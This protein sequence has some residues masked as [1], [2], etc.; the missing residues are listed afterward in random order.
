MDRRLACKTS[1][2]PWLIQ[3]NNIGEPGWQ[4][5]RCSDASLQETAD[6][7]LVHSHSSH[8]QGIALAHKTLLN[9]LSTLVCFNK[10]HNARTYGNSVSHFTSSL[11]VMDET[12]S[13]NTKNLFTVTERIRRYTMVS[14]AR[15]GIPTGDSTS[16][17]CVAAHDR[18]AQKVSAF[19]RRPKL[20]HIDRHQQPW[21]QVHDKI[22]SFHVCFK[23]RSSSF[24]AWNLH[25]FG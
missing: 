20:E 13:S 8:E 9:N 17:E 4:E 11:S 18:H 15:R 7:R 3:T 12:R 2:T 5:K 25:M 19:M 22:S 21:R 24:N 10:S 14:R 16:Y 6:R 1:K 23:R